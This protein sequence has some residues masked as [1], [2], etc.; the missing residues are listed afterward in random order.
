MNLSELFANGY[1]RCQCVDVKLAISRIELT[2]HKQR[3]RDPMKN[4]I[5]NVIIGP[6][7]GKP[8]VRWQATCNQCGKLYLVDDSQR[9]I[10]K[11]VK[12]SGI[13][14]VSTVECD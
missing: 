3:H 2:T 9:K 6:L 5:A 8:R 14:E 12:E 1:R 7:Y 11:L 4:L 10:K 13:E